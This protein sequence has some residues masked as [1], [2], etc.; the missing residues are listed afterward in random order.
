[1]IGWR[2]FKVV[3]VL[4]AGMCSAIP[5][6][7]NSS[8]GWNLKVID[9]IAGDYF[10]SDFSEDYEDHMPYSYENT[11]VSSVEP[12]LHPY[13][14]HST[15]VFRSPD[16]SYSFQY[17]NNDSHREEK[18]DETG[19]VMGSYSYTTDEGQNIKV[20]YRAGP[21][22]GFVIKNWEELQAA[23]L[24]AVSKYS[25]KSKT[26]EKRPTTI[27]GNKYQARMNGHSIIQPKTILKKKGLKDPS[28]YQ[29][30][31][32]MNPG[33]G[34]EEA[35]GRK[36]KHRSQSKSYFDQKN[37][38]KEGIHVFDPMTTQTKILKSV[39]N[40]MYK[41]RQ[42]ERPIHA[43]TGMHYFDPLTGQSVV[44]RH[45]PEKDAYMMYST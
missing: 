22:T 4:V 19:T 12:Y 33:Y 28:Q 14:V 36:H 17:S 31:K 11:P 3:I 7:L 26:K 34:E 40:N 39:K 8:R 15:P 23:V 38:L 9:E 30:N 5:A 27:I 45:E 37:M 35:K 32:G 41:K 42:K 29:S 21:Q 1:M 20:E 44:L 16:P 25:V 2:D 18:A 24:G 10:S 6:P 13:T 43:G